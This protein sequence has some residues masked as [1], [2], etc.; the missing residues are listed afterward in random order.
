MNIITTIYLYFCKSTNYHNLPP[1]WVQ[2]IYAFSSIKK[3]KC[4]YFSGELFVDQYTQE[5]GE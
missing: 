1:P 2:P 3:N 4:N 5:T